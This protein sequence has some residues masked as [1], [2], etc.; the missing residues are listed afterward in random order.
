MKILKFS[1]AHSPIILGFQ[2]GNK[3]FKKFSK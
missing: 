3:Y 2:L 1:Y